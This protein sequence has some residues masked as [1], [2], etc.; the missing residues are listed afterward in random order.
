[1]AFASP[2][3]PLQGDIVESSWP[4]ECSLSAA[5][6]HIQGLL[7]DSPAT[8][9]TVLHASSKPASL[10]EAAVESMTLDN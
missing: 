5:P 6:S 7:P 8:N 4:S 2:E 1:M 3:A 10:A 9:P